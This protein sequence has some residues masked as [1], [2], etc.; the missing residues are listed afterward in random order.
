MSLAQNF[1]M[2]IA[3]FFDFVIL[4][5]REDEG[6]NMALYFANGLQYFIRFIAHYLLT[7]LSKNIFLGPQLC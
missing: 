5:G 1:A 6:L 4:A 2:S 7:V 3:L